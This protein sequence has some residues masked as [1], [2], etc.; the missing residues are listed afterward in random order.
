MK[1]Q[2]KTHDLKIAPKHFAAVADGSKKAEFRVND[3]DFQWRDLLRLREW[4]D[5]DYTGREVYVTV[6]DV[7]DVT[8]YINSSTASRY[9]KGSNFVILSISIIPGTLC[10]APYLR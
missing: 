4:E 1:R 10:R 3:R 2:T 5:G 6:T 9:V 8:N 7:T